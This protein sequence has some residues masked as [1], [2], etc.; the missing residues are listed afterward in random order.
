MNI[1]NDNI[2]NIIN[3]NSNEEI[4]CPKCGSKAIAHTDFVLTSNPPKYNVDCPK[5]GRIYMDC[6]EVNRQI[7]KDPI[8]EN[9]KNN[10]SLDI[11]ND[12][13]G[14]KHLCLLFR[15]EAISTINISEIWMDM[16]NFSK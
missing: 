8:E 11:R 6:S 1:T 3:N 2:V 16:Q 12:L 5:C 14:N 4:T 7:Y 9:I 13:R 10:L 15:E